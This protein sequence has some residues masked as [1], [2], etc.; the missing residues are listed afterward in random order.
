MS[1]FE[2]ADFLVRITRYKESGYTRYMAKALEFDKYGDEYV[3]GVGDAVTRQDAL[4]KLYNEMKI[5]YRQF[6]LRVKRGNTVTDT[7]VKI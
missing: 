1:I 4:N 2:G 7:M 5:E 6:R 3:R